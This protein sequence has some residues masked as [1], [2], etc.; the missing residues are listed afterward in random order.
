MESKEVCGA[1]VLID[2]AGSERIADSLVSGQRKQESVAI[3]KHLTCL[4]DVISALQQERDHIP[5][6][7]SKLTLLLQSYMGGNSK[8]LMIV[9][10]SPLQDHVHETLTSL[11]FARKVNETRVTHSR[12]MFD[13]EN[14]EFSAVP[15]KV[16]HYS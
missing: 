16:K 8:V 9:N 11:N 2:L 12:Q 14:Y 7:N 1:L 13:K 15:S 3:N 5:Y 10:V 6:R 4:S